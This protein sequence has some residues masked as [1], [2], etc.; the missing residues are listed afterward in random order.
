MKKYLLHLIFVLLLLFLFLHFS[1]RMNEPF[2]VM[3][4][5]HT[6]HDYKKNTQEKRRSKS[7]SSCIIS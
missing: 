3:T 2:V 4:R 5:P 1:T 6:V 7:N